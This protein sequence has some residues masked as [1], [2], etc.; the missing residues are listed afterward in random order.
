MKN[1]TQRKTLSNNE[2]LTMEDCIDRGAVRILKGDVLQHYSFIILYLHLVIHT[3]C[4][5]IIDIAQLKK[6]QICHL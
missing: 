6:K 1:V 4:K 2:K 3:Y 5:F